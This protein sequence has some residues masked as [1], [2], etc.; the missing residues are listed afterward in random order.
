MKKVF[1]SVL[2]SVVLIL[3]SL[4]ISGGYSIAKNEKFLDLLVKVKPGITQTQ[5]NNFV[6]KIGGKV[7]FNYHSF[8][9]LA[10]QIPESQLVS[11]IRNPDVVKVENDGEVRIIDSELDN[12]WGIKVIKADLAQAAG[13]TG[14]GVKVAVIDTG[15]Y[16]LH[17]E[18]ADVYKGGYDFVNNDNDP[19]DDNGHGTHCA[20]II[21]AKKDGIG[22]VGVAPNVDLYAVKVIAANGYGQWSTVIAGLQWCIDSGIQVTSN[23]YGGTG[24]SA[25]LESAFQTVYDAGILSVAAAGNSG[26]GET[27]D[28]TIFPARFPSVIAVAA[29]D[30]NNARAYFSSTGPAT[31]ISAPGLNIYSTVPPWGLGNSS[32]YA[33]LSGTSMAGPHIAGVVALVK[34]AHPTWDN[35]TIRGQ[36]RASGIDLGLSGHDWLYG[37]GLVDAY[38]ACGDLISNPPPM[39]SLPPVPAPPIV[40]TNLPTNIADKS[41]TL[42]GSLTS[43]G[44]STSVYVYFLL[45]LLHGNGYATSGK[46]MTSIGDYSVEVVNL[47]PST[48]YYFRSFCNGSNGTF[49]YG[50]EFYFT[51][52]GAIP[53]LPKLIV[54]ELSL[55]YTKN[56]LILLTN[57]I[58]NDG[59]MVTN[60]SVTYNLTSPLGDVTTKTYAT[61]TGSIET[62]IKGNPMDGNWRI[63]II[64]VIGEYPW[65][66]VHSITWDEEGVM[67]RK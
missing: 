31:E 19:M 30:I 26:G 55:Q 21:A 66:Q 8:N 51:T 10:V 49:W 16:Y 24:Y 9:A 12:S 3:S 17:P 27:I 46:T 42:N 15:I 41:V 35:E 48:E 14:S 28:S 44:S 43:M 65:D 13:N 6:T 7:K 64:N 63:D 62:N 20:G 37:F 45:G 22:V 34:S 59:S 56:K 67:R 54:N 36:I 4:F 5:T 29:T 32:G 61:S 25:I 33:F 47:L 57:I 53:V 60:V 11:L 18:L 38:L 1:L 58:R 52:L 40:V 2:V 39:P 50:E 23:S